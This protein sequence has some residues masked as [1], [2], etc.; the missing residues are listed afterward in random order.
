MIAA[1]CRHSRGLGKNGILP[2]K[3]NKDMGH[4]KRMTIGN[5]NNAIIMGRNTWESLSKRSLPKRDNLILSRSLQG[6]NI[7]TSISEV[8]SYCREKE[9]DD[10][11][12]IGGANIYRQWIKDDDIQS[13]H[14]TLIDKKFMCDCFFPEIP[15]NF[16][17]VWSGS[18]MAEED[19]SFQYLIYH[20]E[21]D[22][23]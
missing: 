3:L 4:F 8:K 22:N 15:D 16:S 23:C 6:N 7:F 9:Y 10:I 1:Y 2:W 5:G 14:L 12:I 21:L 17:L 13:L 11:W 19:I 18:E 20:R